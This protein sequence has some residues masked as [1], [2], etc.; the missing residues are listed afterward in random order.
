MHHASK[1]VGKRSKELIAYRSGA[2]KLIML[3][4]IKNEHNGS[5]H[6]IVIRKNSDTKSFRSD[7]VDVN[8]ERDCVL[9]TLGFR[10]LTEK[11][12]LSGSH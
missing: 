4:S 10:E 5:Q 3:S 6:A 8:L 2:G 9:T 11:G 12:Y 1:K 7:N